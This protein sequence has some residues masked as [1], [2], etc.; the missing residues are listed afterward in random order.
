MGI[1]NGG[2]SEGGITKGQDMRQIILDL[3]ARNGWH[4][5]SMSNCE[6]ELFTAYALMLILWV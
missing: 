6:K 5:F 2:V 3:L 1:G 4:N